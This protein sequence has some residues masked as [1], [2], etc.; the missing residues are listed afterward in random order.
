M[1][2]S[3]SKPIVTITGVSGYVGSATCLSFLK[4]GN[5]KVRGTVRSKTNE[6]KIAPLRKAFGEYFD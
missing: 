3:L 4:S 1:V 5:Y 2:E 6:E